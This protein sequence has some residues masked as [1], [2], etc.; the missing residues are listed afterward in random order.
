M[1]GAVNAD[2]LD[3]GTGNDRRADGKGNDD[4]VV[5]SVGDIIT[6]KANE[7]EE[8]V[9]SSISYTFIVPQAAET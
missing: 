5:D 8:I 6:E 2:L 3:G 1:I 4:Y 7:G 9:R